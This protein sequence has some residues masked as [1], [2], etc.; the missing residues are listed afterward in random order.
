M[1]RL[2]AALLLLAA[3]SAAQTVSVSA[4]VSERPEHIAVTIYHEG[5]VHTAELMNSASRGDGLA[6]ISETRTVDL[7]E[8]DSVIQFRGVAATMVP[9]TADI[10]GFPDE[11]SERNFDYGLLSP[12]TL[13]EKS[14]G[15]TVHLVRTDRKTGKVTDEPALVLTGPNGA[16]LKIGN[17]TE[18]LGCSGLPERLVFDR[19]PDG[20]LDQPTLSMRVHAARAGHYALLLRYIAT[21]M[22]WSADYVARINPDGRTLDLSGWITLANISETGFSQAAV[23]VIA[24]HVQTSGDDQPHE[25]EE[26][27]VQNACWPT[28][29]NWA[30]IRALAPMFRMAAAPAPPAMGGALEA[31]VVSSSRIRAIEARDLG[32]LKQYPLPEATDVAAKQSKQVQFLDQAAVPFERVYAYR[33]DEEAMEQSGAILPATILLRL[34]NTQKD[35]LGKPLPAGQIA[36]M[37]TSRSDE[38]LLAE[39]GEVDDTA[40]GLKLEIRGGQTSEVWAQPKLVRSSRAGSGDRQ[41]TIKEMEVTL[42]NQKP[43]P[44]TVE[45]HEIRAE[46]ATVPEESQAHDKRDGD[47]VWTSKLSPGGRSVLRYTLDIPG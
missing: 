36:T 15:E 12:A 46:G 17:R 18:A 21:G 39:Q 44:V 45:W 29:I 41:R 10:A 28:Q 27:A 13:L 11:I 4:I 23:D 8:G 30:K 42:T 38:P 22:N 33:P 1:M 5:V 14:V 7:P 32:D 3:G 43:G 34:Q 9:E 35:G 47:F 16:I 40:V 25:V 24:G 6:M 37:V 26:R 19:V 31:V 2:L 20:L